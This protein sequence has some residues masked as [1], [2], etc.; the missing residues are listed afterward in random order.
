MQSAD[1]VYARAFKGYGKRR[2]GLLGVAVLKELCERVGEKVEEGATVDD[3]VRMIL[4]Y[5][6]RTRGD[7]ASSSTAGAP[8]P[9]PPAS[10]PASPPEPPPEPPPEAP[11]A[12]PLQ[13]R[14]SIFRKRRTIS[15]VAFN[16]LKLR[17]ERDGLEE[18][19]EEIIEEFAEH[20]I[21]AISEVPASERLLR[22]RVKRLMDK[23]QSTSGAHW[24]VVRSQ[25]SGPG[26]LE[27]HLVA[28]KWPLRHEKYATT[29]SVDGLNLC[30]APLTV[31]VRVPPD[32]KAAPPDGKAAPPDRKVVVTSVHFPPASRAKDRDAQI[33]KFVRCYG[34]DGTSVLRLGNPLT[35]KGARD[36][37]VRP[38][39]H[40]I[41]GDFNCW[42]GNPKYEVQKAGMRVLLGE[43]TKTSS[44][45]KA[46]DNFVVSENTTT[47]YDAF[48]RVLEF[49]KS[50]YQNSAK[51]VVGI[52]D[53]S[54]V[55]LTLEW[56]ED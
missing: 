11:P 32:G 28:L 26:N 33:A 42:P 35:D 49:S 36:A 19:W 2:L 54:P 10:P 6:R 43:H 9:P 18:D 55:A 39:A 1:E 41:C 48:A 21:I 29:V 45:G 47:Q 23:L 53:H 7:A 13:E 8:E 37:G 51:G 3:L 16:S 12:S 52:S 17:V 30:H 34:V 25:P 20:D 4:L 56:S 50:A 46:Y 5:K 27:V 31:V 40:V 14:Q 24:T 44:G 22:E 15:I 38:V